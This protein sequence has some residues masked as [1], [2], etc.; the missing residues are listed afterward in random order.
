MPDWLSIITGLV[1]LVLSG[2]LL[3]RG[4]AWIAV[5]CGIR[6]MVVGLTVVAFGTSAPELAASLV[7]ALDDRGGL[8][9][10]TVL[11]SSS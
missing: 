9:T 5:A 1:V 2:D 4:A 7:A 8:A 11:G 6:P 10:G 3:V